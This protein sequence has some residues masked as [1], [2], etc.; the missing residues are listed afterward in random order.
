M[1]LSNDQI[2]QIKDQILMFKNGETW[3]SCYFE[4]KD[5]IIRISDHLPNMENFHRYNEDFE[6][7]YLILVDVN[8]EEE[9]NLNE[10]VE[11]YC[12]NNSRE[13]ENTDYC[14]INDDSDIDFMFKM[15]ERF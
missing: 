8:I 5:T 11:D 14:F 12:N 15:L 7:C 3:K 2:Q 1:T 4:T 6:R 10:A 9:R 13:I